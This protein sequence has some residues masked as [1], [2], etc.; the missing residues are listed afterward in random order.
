MQAFAAGLY[1]AVRVEGT[2]F[3]LPSAPVRDDSDACGA[4]RLRDRGERCDGGRI[5]SRGDQGIAH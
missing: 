1:G 5:G 4:R 3:R 2:A